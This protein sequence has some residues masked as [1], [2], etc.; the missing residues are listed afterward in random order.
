MLVLS[1]KL[2]EEI[3]IGG[4]IKIVVTEISGNRVRIGVEAP[5]DV[6]IRRAELEALDEPT[7]EAA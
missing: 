2:Y 4:E 7:S 6:L 3:T 1:R 5:K